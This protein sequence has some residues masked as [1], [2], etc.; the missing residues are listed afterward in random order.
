MSGLGPLIYL[1]GALVVG[2]AAIPSR[3]GLLGGF[4]L[5]LVLTPL[6][7]LVVVLASELLRPKHG[8]TAAAGPVREGRRPLV[9]ASRPEC[10]RR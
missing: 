5:S 4:L 7:G 1:L 8:G 2:L 3:L 10:D 9:R 6:G